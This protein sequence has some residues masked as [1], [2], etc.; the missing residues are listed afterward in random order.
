MNPDCSSPALQP[1]SSSAAWWFQ[2]ERAWAL[3]LHHSPGLQG[4]GDELL[5]HKA[6][7]HSLGTG[8]KCPFVWAAGSALTHSLPARTSFKAHGAGEM[9][10]ENAKQCFLPLPICCGITKQHFCVFLSPVCTE[11]LH[12]KKVLDLLLQIDELCLAKLLQKHSVLCCKGPV[13]IS[14]YGWPLPGYRWNSFN[15]VLP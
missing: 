5:L 7:F 4:W 6:N 1:S 10:L 12:N 14:E 8:A 11:L 3:L 13:N 2:L 15:H 9:E